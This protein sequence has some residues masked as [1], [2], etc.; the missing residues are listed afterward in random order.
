M[1]TDHDNKVSKKS[2]SATN[3]PHCYIISLLH[4]QSLKTL[5]PIQDLQ[6]V[7]ETSPREISHQ[8][9]TLRF[10]LVGREFGVTSLHHGNDVGAGF[11]RAVLGAGQN[12]AAAQSD[13][14]G[15]L[16]NR[17]RL[18]PTF[19]ENTHQNVAFQAVVLELVAFRVRNILLQRGIRGKE[20]GG[21]GT[22]HNA[23]A[24]VKLGH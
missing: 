24:H 23:I 9:L 7:T 17:R 15:R 2:S 4:L 1:K 18:L 14:D 13:G 21:E 19:L 12:V 11:A 5:N 8:K 16:L 6:S 3:S 20:E 10:A 22:R